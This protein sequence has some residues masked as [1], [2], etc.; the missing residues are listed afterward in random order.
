MMQMGVDASR[1]LCGE[2]RRWLTPEVRQTW[3]G[4]V[5]ACVVK[6]GPWN[7]L[8]WCRWPV[9]WEK[10]AWWHRNKRRRAGAAKHTY[11]KV[12]V[13]LGDDGDSEVW[14]GRRWVHGVS[15]DG[16]YVCW[17][18]SHGQGKGQSQ[19]M[20]GERCSRQWRTLVPGV[21]AG[22]IGPGRVA[23]CTRKANMGTDWVC[24]GKRSLQWGCGNA[25]G[26]GNIAL[27]TA[28][29]VDDAGSVVGQQRGDQGMRKVKAWIGWLGA[30]TRDS[31]GWLLREGSP[32]CGW[33]GMCGKK[34]EASIELA[35]GGKED[36]MAVEERVGVLE[37]V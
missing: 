19:G 8:W 32:G 7:R 10:D 26:E 31:C 16:K 9:G 17:E 28:V 25:Y 27:S 2:S 15:G 14:K 5:V 33:G 3:M 29:N 30:G 22:I 35:G 24:G 13:E 18:H 37:V 6:G 21:G 12:W 36:L 23:L 1:G 4:Y 20:C 34:Q 11:E